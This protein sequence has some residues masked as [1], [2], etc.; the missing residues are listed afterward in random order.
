MAKEILHSTGLS[1]LLLYGG[2][3]NNKYLIKNAASETVLC[4]LS[5]FDVYTL[6]KPRKKT[7][8]SFCFALRSSSLPNEKGYCRFFCVEKPERLFDWV[9]AL[10]LCK[11]IF[12][13]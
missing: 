8:T 5:V 9:L 13:R 12:S 6:S 2:K 10:R 11:V 1:T 7:P 3:C 4:N